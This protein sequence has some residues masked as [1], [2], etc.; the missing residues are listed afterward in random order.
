MKSL[1]ILKDTSRT[2]LLISLI[3]LVNVS[4]QAKDKSTI[5][6]GISAKEVISK[7]KKQKQAIYKDC[8]I[9]GKIDF[10]Q[11]SDLTMIGSGHLEAEVS[12]P[13]VF[14]NCIF[15]D[16]VTS[17]G[18]YSNSTVT[19]RF[20]RQVVFEDCDFRSNINLENSIFEYPVNLAYSK[21]SK[22]IVLSGSEFKSEQVYLNKISALSKCN[23]QNCRFHGD[24]Y[25]NDSQFE[26]K[27]SLQE[28]TIG[29][30]LY[31]S[32]LQCKGAIDLS[33]VRIEGR[34]LLNYLHAST[35]VLISNA[36]FRSGIEII[37][38]KIDGSLFFKDNMI[39][40]NIKLN[41][42][43]VEDL[44]DLTGS[45]FMG[46]DIELK[47]LSSN[48]KNWQGMIGEVRSFTDRR[49]EQNN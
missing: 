18:S 11:V 32:N 5:K 34:T 2:I 24:L 42:T 26:D 25:L 49:I 19:T 3:L 12:V 23:L 9:T 33:L 36:Q 20:L 44:I 10:T 43:K 1:F 37:E 47:G 38:G 22:S 39:F 4:C 48:K 40:K 8:I 30:N 31:A 27:L 35:S 21:F 17:M 29:N 28:A 6:N 16:S 7:I 46:Q 41:N 45:L 15:L 13:V 14:I